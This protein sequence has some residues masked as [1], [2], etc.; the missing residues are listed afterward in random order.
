M[1]LVLEKR[2]Q[3]RLLLDVYLKQHLENTS[4][5]EDEYERMK[6]KS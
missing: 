4:L 2:I 5:S 6:F 1:A 3:P